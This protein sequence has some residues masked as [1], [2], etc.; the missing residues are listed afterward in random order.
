MTSN[1]HSVRNRASVKTTARLSM[2]S[3]LAI[4]AGLAAVPVQAQSMVDPSVMPMQSPVAV[5]QPAPAPVMQPSPSETAPS[6]SVTMPQAATTPSVTEERADALAEKGGFNAETVAPEAL[7]QIER[8]QQAR[9]EAAAKSAAAAQAAAARTAAARSARVTSGNDA[10]EIAETTAPTAGTLPAAAVDPVSAPGFE[11][12][13]LANESAVAPIETAEAPA[14]VPADTDWTLLA[15]L[16]GLLGIAGAGA[17]GLTRRRKVADK[18]PASSD[19]PTGN[20]ATRPAA[21]KAATMPELRR[22]PVEPV[23]IPETASTQSDDGTKDHMADFIAGLPSFEESSS[24]GDRNVP[25]AQRRVAAAPRP[26]L[27]EADMKRS[28][29]YFTSHVDAMPTP[30]NPFL[31]RQKRLKRARYLDAKLSEMR[32]AK[33]LTPNGVKGT[34]QV[35]RPMEPAYS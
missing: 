5:P 21:V 10:N 31:T 16:A 32:S 27:G 2:I 30:Q 7:A 14:D 11:S 8:E 1:N 12:A 13:P 6:A 35:S 34:M 9:Q 15:A 24:Q 23:T 19:A 26:Y 4:S 25:I 20:A 22:T 3:L 33:A 17:Y 18:T 28:P 29:G